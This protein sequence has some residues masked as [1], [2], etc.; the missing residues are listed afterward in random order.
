[1]AILNFS[2]VNIGQ[3]GDIPTLIYFKTNDSVE[4]VTT[5]GYLN[6][7]V[8]QGNSLS[9][10]NMALVSTLESDVQ[11]LQLYSVK[12][13]SPNWSLEEY[14]GNP[15]S[16]IE[17]INALGD[18]ITLQPP[19]SS[20]TDMTYTF[21]IS[22]PSTSGFVLSSTTDGVMSWI[23]NG[24]GGGGVTGAANVG[25]G[26]GLFYQNSAGL[27]EFYSLEAAAG[28]TLSLD[29]NVLVGFDPTA[30]FDGTTN[31]AITGNYLFT[32]AFNV[33]TAQSFNIEVTSGDVGIIS[34]S[35]EMII[36]SGGGGTFVICGS[37]GT[38]TLEASADIQM[39]ASTVLNLI[40][41]AG[42]ATLQ[43]TGGDATLQ[44]TTGAANLTGFTSS[45]I[46][47]P[48]IN[49]T[50][51]SPINASYY[52]NGSAAFV[53]GQ[54]VSVPAGPSVARVNVQV[55]LTTAIYT[56]SA[57]LVYAMIECVGSGGGGGGAAAGLTSISS[58]GGGSAGS[59]SRSFLSAA[60]IT[61]SQTVTVPTG[62]AGGAIGS[63]GTAGAATT[64]GSLVTTVGGLGGTAG[65]V[66]SGTFVAVGGAS[67]TVGGTIA[68]FKVVGGPGGSG[69]GTFTGLFGLAGEGGTSYFGG[70]SQAPISNS[71]GIAAT[72]WGAG[73]SGGS[74]VSSATGSTGGGGASGYC[75]VTEYI[76]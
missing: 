17:L 15:F 10:Y 72:V 9:Q 45:T 7:F 37:T 41:N 1:M 18:S 34:D 14:N 32:G 19:A 20:F 51:T 60:T 3:S 54:L 49:L 35:G 26:S 13:V 46:S 27:L 44:S 31:P 56:A 21:P 6:K 76:A 53:S 28:V 16:Y 48:T 39:E 5:K 69:W 71:A 11:S 4:T 40:S 36:G 64:F 38:L 63:T 58:G 68:Q 55:F 65:T 59:Y 47:A 42:Y 33:T 67:A 2:I 23:S 57:N 12:H 70:G 25:T 62:G 50:S 30:S 52:A 61:T 8:A 24:S 66:T 73:G 74:V 29:D 22:L 75:I 43:A